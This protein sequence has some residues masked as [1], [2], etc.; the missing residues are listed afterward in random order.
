MSHLSERNEHEPQAHEYNEPISESYETMPDEQVEHIDYQSVFTDGQYLMHYEDGPEFLLNPKGVYAMKYDKDFDDYM[1]A[2]KRLCTP[3]YVRSVT[4]NSITGEL[5]ATIAYKLQGLEWYELELS[6]Q[7]INEGVS[8]NLSSLGVVINPTPGNKP[9]LAHYLMLQINELTHNSIHEYVGFR[10]QKRIE[11]DSILFAHQAYEYERTE[12]GELF[13]TESQVSERY[14]KAVTVKGDADDLIQRLKLLFPHKEVKFALAIGFSALLHGY[15]KLQMPDL[16]NYIIHLHGNSSTGKTTAA[17]LAVS[18]GGSPLDAPLKTSWD[19]TPNVL[20]NGFQGNFGLPVLIDE[21][22]MASRDA[23]DMIYQFSNGEER[24]RLG[25]DS[26]QRPRA[27]F[28]TICVSTGEQSLRNL[29]RHGRNVKNAGVS[30]RAIEVTDLN[31]M[32][33]K[34]VAETVSKIIHEHH[35]ILGPIFAEGLLRIDPKKVLAS[36]N[37]TR[38]SYESLVSS[39]SNYVNRLSPMFATLDLSIRLAYSYFFKSA[40]DDQAQ[41]STEFQAFRDM[42]VHIFE[43][44]LKTLDIAN[45]AYDQFRNYVIT[46]IRKF[47]YDSYRPV[48]NDVL[49]EIK[50]IRHPNRFEVFIL[51]EHLHEFF[52]KAG[53]TSPKVVLKEWKAKGFI[54]SD[55]DR[56]TSRTKTLG[57]DRLTGY[58]ITF[59]SGTFDDYL[60]T[61]AELSLRY[62]PQWEQPGSQQTRVQQ[63]EADLQLI[64][65]ELPPQDGDDI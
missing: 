63:I 35:G 44:Q 33:S 50:P 24:A 56:I 38:D 39:S 46:H 26:R 60:P 2:R 47:K 32:P 45:T 17:K 58:R 7:S 3:M 42:M 14:R 52:R 11:G 59:E 21:S 23:S 54:V 64:D 41:V 49:G 1:P 5:I 43:E 28:A 15:L 27:V 6:S 22:S 62:G 36:W 29:D 61:E 18:V 30:V 40:E 4:R 51:Q 25:R 55:S 65:V 9:L 10:K 20:L 13:I 12:T 34:E 8:S 16:L 19:A 53:Y 57:N 31:F 48:S 37:R